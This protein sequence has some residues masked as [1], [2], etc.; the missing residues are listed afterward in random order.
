TAPGGPPAP[1][2]VSEHN[3]R[4][5]LTG[6]GW[7]ITDLRQT[8]YFIDTAAGGNLFTD[9]YYERTEDNT[10][11]DPHV[12]AASPAHLNGGQAALVT[13]ERSLTRR[14]TVPEP[15]PRG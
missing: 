14:E 12:D 2:R 1:L 5:T 11:P 8:I 4:T 10:R 6:A 15:E 13:A 7:T 9:Q 3:L